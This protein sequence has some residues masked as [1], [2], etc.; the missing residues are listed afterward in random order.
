M[1]S[2]TVK[3]DKIKPNRGIKWIEVEKHAALSHPSKWIQ[4]NDEKGLELS[5]GQR[6]NQWQRIHQRRS[7]GGILLDYARR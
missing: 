6:R 3:I 7:P 2:C 4:G 1:R 5:V